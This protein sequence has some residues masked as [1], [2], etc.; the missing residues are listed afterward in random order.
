[1]VEI[2]AK[3]KIEGR[4]KNRLNRR[5]WIVQYEGNQFKTNYIEY[6]QQ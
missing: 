3:V 1:M 4:L 6:T 2:W 5:K